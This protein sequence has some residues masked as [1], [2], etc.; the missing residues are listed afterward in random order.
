MNEQDIWVIAY[1]DH[2]TAV[3]QS[4][5]QSLD[6]FLVDVLA[7]FI[8]GCHVLPLHPSSSDGGF[9]VIDPA[10]VDEHY[11][12]WADVEQLASNGSWMADAVVNHLSVR[13]PWFRAYLDRV[14][15]FDRFFATLDPTIDASVVSRPRTSPLTHNFQRADGTVA[16][17]WTT[18]SADQ[19]DLDY[20][21]H[22]VLAA[23]TDVVLRYA[24]RGATA[25]RLDAIG[26]V[27]KDPV[28]SSL[29]RPEAH[30]VV[31]AFR[32]A[33]DVEAP[34][35]LLIT[36]TN[37]PHDENVAYL[38]P[39]EADAVYQ[40]ALPPLVAYTVL[41][42]DARPL[43]RWLGSVEFPPP[44]K[45]FLNFL[46]SHDGIG[47]RPAEGILV[48][49][50]VQL[51]VDATIDAGGVVNHRTAADGCEQPYELA[52][53]WFSL[54]SAGCTQDDAIARHLA[55]HAIAL[56]VRGLPLIYL[57]SLF[58]IGNDATAY[59]RSGHGRDL[60]RRRVQRRQIDGLLA[61][62]QSLVARVW[63]GLTTM[64]AFR[65]SSPAFHPSSDQIVH[66]A[67]ADVVMIERRAM[68]GER[69]LVVVNV[70]A[71]ALI[72]PLAPG[73]WGQPSEITLAPWQALWLVA[74]ASTGPRS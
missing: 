67:G 39:G 37:V 15:P 48:N 57:N 40:F 3:D 22:D 35:V 21:N 47:L 12:T 45:F 18:F 70:S 23:M 32:T 68:G 2:V 16:H 69:A 4:A 66:G 17:V 7:P 5:L 10:A 29:N 49:E 60:N 11:G 9:S 36:E 74:G 63:R 33:L 58:G 61:D 14:A 54:M 34:D 73:D 52:V 26:F 27:G 53:S 43:C 28:T 51:L 50:Q 38:A 1:P 31:R 71:D 59:E 44:P 41:A 20:G 30:A 55:A 25:I 64:I 42:S 13:S 6:T 19:V 46:A 65:R 62:D 8:T 56:A 72:T 24:R